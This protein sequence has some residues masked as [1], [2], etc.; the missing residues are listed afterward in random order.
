MAR[1]G[2]KRKS[3]LERETHKKSRELEKHMKK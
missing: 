2:R 3:N 1:K